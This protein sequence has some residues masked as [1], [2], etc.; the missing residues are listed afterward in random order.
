MS[1]PNTFEDLWGPVLRARE[2]GAAPA[3]SERLRKLEEK[4]E[5]RPSGSPVPIGLSNYEDTR[6]VRAPLR[7]GRNVAS[8]DMNVDIKKDTLSA[9][10]DR[11]G[12]GGGGLPDGAEGDI[13]YHDGDDWVVLPAPTGMTANPALRFNISTTAP[14][15]DEPEG[16]S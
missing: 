7:P 3:M 4:L 6:T 10:P 14:Y 16:C 9:D 1:R 13:L 15:W 12:G 5:G 8:I 11:D 2:Q